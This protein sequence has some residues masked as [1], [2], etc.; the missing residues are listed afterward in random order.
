MN[1]FLKPCTL[2]KFLSNRTF[3]LPAHCL[4]ADF[5]ILTNIAA[6]TWRILQERTEMS[7][8]G[9]SD[10][11]LLVNFVREIIC[12]KESQEEASES[13][14][15]LCVEIDKVVEDQGIRSPSKYIEAL[16]L[17]KA[18]LLSAERNV[19]TI[20]LCEQV[21]D[22]ARD[23]L[24][25]SSVGEK[26]LGTELHL[27]SACY[28]NIKNNNKAF[29]AASCIEYLHLLVDSPDVRA[30]I[31]STAKGDEDTTVF[32]HVAHISFLRS[33][34]SSATGGEIILKNS[35]GG[36]DSVL[37]LLSQ[38]PH[39]SLRSCNDDNNGSTAHNNRITSI[40][41]S[42]DRLFSASC[43]NTIKVWDC[44]TLKGIK[45]LSS[46]NS[47][48]TC[49]VVHIQQL[50]VAT[51]DRVVVVWDIATLETVGTLRGHD[52]HIWALAASEGRVYTGSNDRHIRVFDAITFAEL[53]ELRR[54]TYTVISFAVAGDKLYSGSL[55]GSI[56]VW[57]KST[58]TKLHSLLSHE[59][60]VNALLVVD[61]RLISGSFDKTVKVWATDTYTEL[62]TLT[63]THGVYSL[64]TAGNRL[65]VGSY[66]H[67][68]HVWD[69]TSY[70]STAQL[71]G[72]GD[73][74]RSL[75]LHRGKLIS[76]SHDHSIHVR[77]I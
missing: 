40:A 36:N 41:V 66:D 23:L 56:K 65:F 8:F 62:A 61:K 68:I 30:F 51:D 38:C 15:N 46:N 45:T 14:E 10:N 18:I 29:L 47:F 9:D 63:Q 52:G 12:R 69:L 34:L 72:H 1:L 75:V 11:G 20:Q 25:H 4:N 53:P 71:Q 64:A 70:E 28:L 2:F 48:A 50:Y 58:M 67:C 13:S 6:Q 43:D 54:E 35:I 32:G 74:V 19:T 60:Y 55:D 76:A 57:S 5:A 21:Q 7:T 26:I 59:S 3:L 73:F 44:N 31:D 22:C 77:L 42:D 16:R 24:T 17:V 37:D 33:W 39:R 49:M 27:F